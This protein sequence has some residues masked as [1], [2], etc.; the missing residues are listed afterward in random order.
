VE[1]GDGSKDSNYG[2]RLKAK[3]NPIE[4]EQAKRTSE[5]MKTFENF[6]K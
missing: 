2:S 1:I 4:W 3:R 5:N 6:Q